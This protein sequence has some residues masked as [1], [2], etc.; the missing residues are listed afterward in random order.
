MTRRAGVTGATD[1]VMA[2]VLANASIAAM[3][4]TDGGAGPSVAAMLEEIDQ[5]AQ[6]AAVL[7]GQLRVFKSP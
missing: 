5:S 3:D 4:I 6:R 2:A 7:Y 1:E